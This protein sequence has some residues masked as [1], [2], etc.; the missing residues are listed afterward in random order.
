MR[1]KIFLVAAIAAVVAVAAAMS[2]CAQIQAQVLHDVQPILRDDVAAALTIAEK[3]PTTEQQPIACYSGLQTWVDNLPTTAA[4]LEDPGQVKGLI[5]G[6]ELVRLGIL[7]AS[8]PAPAIPPLDTATYNACLVAFSDT[9][10]AA[11]KLAAVLSGLA[12]GRSLGQTAAL[13]NKASALPV[14][15]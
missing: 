2:G 10:M 15:P 6:G 13:L 1:S 3:R 14:K 11:L 12:K 9:K 7:D 5:S 4:P 8:T